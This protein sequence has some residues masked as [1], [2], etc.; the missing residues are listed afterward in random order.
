MNNIRSCWIL[1]MRLVL[2]SSSLS[3]L[4]SNVAVGDE[5]HF[6]IQCTYSAWKSRSTDELPGGKL[7]FSFD[8]DKKIYDLEIINTVPQFGFQSA[9]PSGV[10][11]FLSADQLEIVTLDGM[12]RPT[13]V[14]REE[15][16]I[17]R[18]TGAYHW[19]GTYRDESGWMRREG[20]CVKI[21]F[22]PIRPSAF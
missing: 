5:T 12:F 16:K 13:A 18:T 15:E 22:V 1:A 19:V 9:R 14:L 11:R 7:R 3:I 8:L 4:Y 2:L 17:N 6:S 20:Q 21:P 10:Y